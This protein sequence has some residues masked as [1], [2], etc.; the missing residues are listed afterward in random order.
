[1]RLIF[2]KMMQARSGVHYVQP[3][4]LW[5]HGWDNGSG[6]KKAVADVLAKVIES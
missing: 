2:E 5:D 1:M 3:W 4:T 6:V